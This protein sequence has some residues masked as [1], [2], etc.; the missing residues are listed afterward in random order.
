MS[1]PMVVY[2]HV[3][4]IWFC[5]FGL[6]LGSKEMSNGLADV[7]VKLVMLDFLTVSGVFLDMYPQSSRGGCRAVAHA[8]L[9]KL[10]ASFLLFLMHWNAWSPQMSCCFPQ[11]QFGGLVWSKI[12]RRSFLLMASV[13]LQLGKWCFSLLRDMEIS[14]Y[15][16]WGDR[17]LGRRCVCSLAVW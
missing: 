10:W 15:D 5:G 1:A 12:G 11:A 7:S 2:G 6:G 4:C 17:M 9:M 14:G 13:K 8:A 3:Q 16:V